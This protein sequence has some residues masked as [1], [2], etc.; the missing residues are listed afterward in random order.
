MTCEGAL[1]YGWPAMTMAAARTLLTAPGAPF[2]METIAIRG[3]ETRIWKNAPP[4]LA[5]LMDRTRAHGDRLFVI[6]EDERVSYEGNYRATATLAHWMRA[7]GIGKGDRVALA[8]RN[9]PEWPPIFFAAVSIG[10]IVVPLNAW[11]TG[12]ELATCLADAGPTMLFCD[13]ERYERIASHLAALP[14]LSHVV[15]ARHMPDVMPGATALESIIGT[16]AGYDGLPITAFPV[17]DLMPDDDATI[18]FTSGTTGNS[19]G[20]IGTHRNVVTNI[21]SSGYAAARNFLRRGE[22]LSPAAPKVRLTPVPLF[23]VTGCSASLIAGMPAGNTNILMPRWDAG[24]ALGIIARERV[25]IT[26]GVPTIVWQLLEHPDRDSFDLSSLETIAYGGAPSAPELVG[27]IALELSAVPGNGWGMT[28]TGGTV[29]AVSA[30][31]YQNRPDSCGPPVAVADL[32]IMDADGSTELPIGEIGELWARGPMVARGYWNRP[33]ATAATFVKGWVRTGDLARLD[34]EGFCTIVD[35]AKDVIIRG[36][37]NIYSAE[38]ES[39]LYAHP[40]VT[41]AALIGLP[42]RTL[43][44]VPAAVVHLVAGISATEADLQAWVRERLAG[45]K[46]PEHI[47][48]AADMLPR[49]PG[50]KVLKS[51]LRALFSDTKI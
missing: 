41:D 44:E 12:F 18:F 17:I 13:A 40:A 28:E 1:P 45:F 29:C 15:V 7:M 47:L 4:T 48:F 24:K 46:V 42:H 50:G 27:R 20:A 6:C 37:E 38:V 43:G 9:L 10:A 19:K 33:E 5:A 31:D 22:P 32:R 11:W 39:V 25:Q 3:V 30:E 51:D 14:G 36:G 21:L 8:M 16:P 35:R 26:G 23:H 49:N 34:A 2:E